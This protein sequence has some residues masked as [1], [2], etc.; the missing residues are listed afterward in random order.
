MTTLSHL[1]TPLKVGKLEIKN[2]IMMPGMSAGMMLDNDAH[3]LPE[4]TAYFVE[5]AKA[6]P[7]LMA[8]GASAV[9]PPPTHQRAPVA[10]YHDKYVPT[11]AA[12]VDAVHRY[13]TK[14]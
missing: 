5:R 3:V 7:G 13:D 9:V 14:F 10:L 8:V 6:R 11:L 2:R 4:M 1:F 12:M